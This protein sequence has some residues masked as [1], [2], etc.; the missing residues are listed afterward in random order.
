MTPDSMP[1][2][3]T[4]CVGECDIYFLELSESGTTAHGWDEISGTDPEFSPDG[5]L[6]AFVVPL[7][8]SGAVPDA[9]APPSPAL[10]SSDAPTS[11]C[12]FF[13][14]TCIAGSPDAP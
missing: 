11:I 12:S 13:I 4:S 6:V 1:L 5:S 14:A 7:R 8:A 10:D 3:V 2:A 9:C